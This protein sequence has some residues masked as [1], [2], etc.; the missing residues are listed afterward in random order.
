MNR[1]NGL[2]RIYLHGLPEDID[3]DDIEKFLNIK[4]LEI[5]LNVVDAFADL[6]CEADFR[7][8][9]MKSGGYLNRRRVVV[10]FSTE[11]R[12]L[13]KDLGVALL[14]V[15][16]GTTHKRLAQELQNF[17]SIEAIEIQCS[18]N[19]S[20]IPAF[21]VFKEKQHAAAAIATKFISIEGELVHILKSY[22]F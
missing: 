2:Y 17:G 14:N 7:S 8:A 15:P 4:P 1:L 13:R 21:V 3:E 19:G 6:K 18:K 9:I 5:R 20:T 16:R 10:T 22:K 12:A 11:A